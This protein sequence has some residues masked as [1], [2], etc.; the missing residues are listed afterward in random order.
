MLPPSD[1]TICRLSDS[2]S[3]VPC[4][5]RA[6]DGCTCTKGSKI[7]ARCA[8][9]IPTPVS[10]TRKTTPSS[11]LPAVTKICP[12]SVNLHALLT[13]FSSTCSTRRSSVSTRGS[14]AAAVTSRVL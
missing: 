7:R 14:P 4:W 11:S 1:C 12:C 3:P 9:D 5:R 10:R 2:P 8:G 13:R 6:A